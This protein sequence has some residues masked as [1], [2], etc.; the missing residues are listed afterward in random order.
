MLFSMDVVVPFFDLIG[1]PFDHP[2]RLCQALRTEIVATRYRFRS[3][4]AV[5]PFDADESL[6]QVAHFS[7]ARNA[8]LIVWWTENLFDAPKGSDLDAWADALEPLSR[9]AERWG[10]LGLLGKAS[11]RA[12]SAF[13]ESGNRSEYWK[14]QAAVFKGPLSDWDLH[15]Y[16]VNLFEDHDP[17]NVNPSHFIARSLRHYAALRFWSAMSG[18]HS[19]AE[20]AR[21]RTAAEFSVRERGDVNAELADPR[22]LVLQGMP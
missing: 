10:E 19:P 6:R 4:N 13:I 21:L 15:L 8:E 9:D 3:A 2:E 16:A 7:G 17:A 12:R 18:W 22:E 11:E 20:L 1:A 14:L 5:P